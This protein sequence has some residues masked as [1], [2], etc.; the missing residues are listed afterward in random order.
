MCPVAA[1]GRSVPARWTPDTWAE[2][3]ESLERIN[4]IRETNGSFD[5]CNSCE[6]LVPSCLHELHKLKPPFAS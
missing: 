3:F 6:R 2:K 5:S 1:A 4:S